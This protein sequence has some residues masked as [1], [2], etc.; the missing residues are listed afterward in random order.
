[1]ADSRTIWLITVLAHDGTEEVTLRYSDAGY[2]SKPSDT[3]SNAYFENIVINPGSISRSLFSSGTTSG[4]I[5]VGYGRI[6]LANEDGDLD[7][8]KGYGWGRSVTV[9]SITTTALDE[10][11]EDLALTNAVTR[12]KGIVHHVE[13]DFETLSLVIRD[14]LGRLN[15]PIQESDFDGSSTGATGI[16]G[17]ENVEGR[18]KPMSWGAGIRNI[19][20]AQ[21][22]A[23]KE[24]YAWRF[25]KSGVPLPS[26]ALT[27]LR[28]GGATYVLSGTDHAD[29]ATL[30][31]ATLA[32]ANADTCLAESL[33]RAN[34]SVTAALT[35]DIDVAP[36]VINLLF[37]S[38]QHSHSTWLNIGSPTVTASVAVAPDGN[39]TADQI[40]FGAT[41]TDQLYQNFS[42]TSGVTYTWAFYAKSAPGAGAQKLRPKIYD[43]SVDTNGTE[44]DLTED[45]WTRIEQ[46]FTAAATGTLNVA[47]RNASTGNSDVLV[48]GSM[49]VVGSAAKPY[50]PTS[51]NLW[52]YSEQLDNGAWLLSAATVSANAI[53]SPDGTVNAEKITDS[54]TTDG[55]G[56]YRSVTI[57]A[58]A[59]VYTGSIL[60][61]AA[62]RSWAYIWLYGASSG[63]RGVAW[64]NLTTGEVSSVS[65]IGT[66]TNTTASSVDMGGGWWRLVLTT[67]TDASGS[68]SVFFAMST[69]DGVAAYLGDAASGIYAVA[70]QLNRGAVRP[71]VKTEAVLNP[72][73]RAEATAARVAE[74]IL[75]E[76]GYSIEPDSL[77]A[78]DALAPYSVGLYVDRQITILEAAQMALESVGAYI[79]ATNLGTFRVGR[80]QAP[81]GTPDITIDESLI[82]DEGGAALQFIPTDSA[83]TGVPSQKLTVF[84]SPN[85]TKQ[86][87]DALAGSVSQSDRVKWGE[88]SL[89]VFSENATIATKHPEAEETEI[90]T[91]LSYEFDARSE[92]TRRLA[93]E[94]SEKTRFLSPLA[95]SDAVWDVDGST[96]VDISNYVDLVL[97]R[98]GF[99]S[100]G[101]FVVIGVQ[102]VFDENLV[103]LDVINSSAW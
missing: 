94:S 63:N 38:E 52:T 64:I 19:S 4:Q 101:D 57:P 24:V 71:Y 90:D 72:P 39:T 56:I 61:K 37:Y 21:V 96:P 22:N 68:L 89:K 23:S 100:G 53:I 16:E 66:F 92:A 30:F 76:H 12:F 34:G 49:L 81:S 102:E 13:A 78:L 44:A 103:V 77:L 87:A 36:E 3:P 45:S 84:F 27:A 8:L 75:A 86:N 97:A 69:G 60:V 48:W 74:A 73:R 51:I 58:E 9:Q 1:M 29:Q 28:N 35:A 55:H 83:N 50:V 7:A 70:A 31:G 88:E 80:F 67:T 41:A 40:E 93:F 2:T 18:I 26:A 10:H 17:N 33:F 65:S 6:I 47:I 42:G 59:A 11:P 46:T 79:I 15:V 14:E 82:G 95:A 20:P 91:I 99:D 32:S 25:D 62:E 98:F 43:G 5:S 85:W 54:G